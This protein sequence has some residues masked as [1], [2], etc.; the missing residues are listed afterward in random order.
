MLLQQTCLFE[1]EI[2]DYDDGCDAGHRW[3]AG[4]ELVRCNYHGA[5]IVSD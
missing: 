3:E 1:V 4:R 2:N 5:T